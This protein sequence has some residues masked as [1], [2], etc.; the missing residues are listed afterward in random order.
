M[1]TNTLHIT[2]MT[3]FDFSLPFDL[4]MVVHATLIAC[5]TFLVTNFM[6][7]IRFQRYLSR[8]AGKNHLAH[9]YGKRPG[10]SSKIYVAGSWAQRAYLQVKMNELRK[11]NYVVTSDW[12]TFETKLDNPDDYAECSRLDI[13]GVV[14]ADTVLAFMTD[15]IYPYRG[16]YTEIGCAIGSGRRIILICDGICTKKN[17]NDQKKSDERMS[18]NFE[19]TFSHT[20]MNNVFFWDP[21]I[22]HVATFDDAL[23][24][25]RG[26]KV[27]S[28]Y[29]HCYSGKI[30]DEMTKNSDLIKNKNAKQPD[31]THGL[32]EDDL[33]IKE[34]DLILTN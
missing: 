17:R 12:P 22:E 10:R 30:S 23:K 32:P 24:L 31:I 8:M 28:P 14:N 9:V 34:S 27:D 6:Y 2:V 18:D 21:R 3:I 20:C 11:L 29:A 19:F 1:Y 15:S 4:T 33:V 25:M 7:D 13:D 26:E 16:T 5:I